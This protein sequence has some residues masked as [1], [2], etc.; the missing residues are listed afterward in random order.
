MRAI[1]QRLVA[2]AERWQDAVLARAERAPW[3]ASLLLVA[4]VMALHLGGM[5]LL[6]PL[7]RTAFGLLAYASAANGIV[8]WGFSLTWNQAEKLTKARARWRGSLARSKTENERPR[9]SSMSPSSL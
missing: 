8:T 3:Q 6:P 7:D 5:A 1:M 4:L 9:Y 2:A